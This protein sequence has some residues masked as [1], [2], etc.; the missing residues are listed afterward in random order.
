MALSWIWTF[1]VAVSVIFGACS[2][3]IRSVSD[4][5]VNGAAE[6]AKFCL[7]F[8][9]P[10]CLWSGVLELMKRAGISTRLARIL[11]TPIR[12]LF[13]DAKSTGADEAIAENISA[14]LLGLGNAATPAGMR[15]A[16]ALAA[17]AKNG[18]A[19][20]DLCMLVVLN[21]ASIQLIPTSVAAI[22]AANGA[23]NAFDILP[24]VWLASA[25]ALAAGLISAKLFSLCGRKR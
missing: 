15:A 4:A 21:T 12:R 16:K 9:G 25:A 11:R 24:C 6:A 20:D 10:V 1:A 19:T 14:N 3:N 22:R 23:E 7:A 2:G 5:A 13:P 18:E 8:A 17:R